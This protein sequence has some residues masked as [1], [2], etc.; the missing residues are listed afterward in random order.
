MLLYPFFGVLFPSFD[1]V[2]LPD[3]LYIHIR[4]DVTVLYQQKTYFLVRYIT[5][6]KGERKGSNMTIDLKRSSH[7]QFNQAT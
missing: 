3:V 5:V 7:R 6:G 4:F 1:N 2:R